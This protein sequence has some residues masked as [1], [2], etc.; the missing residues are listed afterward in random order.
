MKN[1]E[2]L[3][4]Y[5]DYLISAFGQTTATGFMFLGGKLSHDQFN[6]C[7]AQERRV[8]PICGRLSNPMC[9]R[10]NKMMAYSSLDDSIAEK[11]Y[12]DENEII[13][14]HYDHS[15]RRNIKG[16]NFVTCLY[17]SQADSLPVGFRIGCENRMLHRSKRGQ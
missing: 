4:I 3:D 8:M 17:H 5:S 9:A 1:S 15:K 7:L 14:W 2:L 16:I 11:P 6:G 10:S 13:C 12:T